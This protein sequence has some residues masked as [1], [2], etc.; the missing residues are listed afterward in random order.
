MKSFLLHILVSIMSHSGVFIAVFMALMGKNHGWRLDESHHPQDDE[1]PLA[2]FLI[3]GIAGIAI[4]CSAALLAGLP[5]TVDIPDWSHTAP[6]APA[7]QQL[8]SVSNP[9]YL[10][11]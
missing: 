6:V 11:V 4:T 9:A 5:V 7:A 8:L 2:R 10:P 1:G 3:V